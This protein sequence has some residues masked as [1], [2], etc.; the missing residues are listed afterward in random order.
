[1]V[2][3]ELVPGG[4]KTIFD[5]PTMPLHCHQFFQRCANR[6]PGREE[7]EITVGDVAADQQPACPDACESHVEIIG[8]KISEFKIGPVMQSRALGKPDVSIGLMHGAKGQEFR[9]VAGMA[10]DTDVLPDEARLLAASGERPSHFTEFP[11]ICTTQNLQICN[12]LGPVT[13]LH[14]SS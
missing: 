7:G 10:C 2:E 5:R 11:A 13:P 3:A 4:L 9:A 12:N 8:V 6:T 14:K 1:M